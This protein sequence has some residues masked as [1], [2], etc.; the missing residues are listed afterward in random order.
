[1]TASPIR[2][3]ILGAADIAPDA[4]INP[5]KSVEE[6]EITSVA[7][8]DPR[9]AAEFA[10]EHGIP[11]VLETYDALLADPDI[12]LIYNPTPNGL[13]GR[14]TVAA[15]QAG[16]HVLCEKPF[17]ANAAEAREVAAAIARADRIVI[18]AFHYRYHPLIARALEIS[19]SGELGKVVSIEAGFGGMG[20]PLDDI[21]WSLPLAGGALMDVGCYP[22]HLVRTLAGAQPEVVAARA[23]MSE[24]GV[25]ADMD[26]DLRFPEGATGRVRTSMQSPTQFLYATVTGED[27]VLEIENPFIPMKGNSLTVRSGSDVRTEKFTTE[28][29]YLFQLRAV[30]DVLLRG[31]PVLTD[32][33]DAIANMDVI[34]AAYRAA[35]LEP[36]SPTV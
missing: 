25:D 12:D 13:H 21:R 8:R 20:R 35:G 28:P 32:T 3:G 2:V 31:A 23:D 10:A 16:K 18:E 26:I 24:T 1:M 5:A 33:A 11:R 34:D 17:T 30:A 29:S 9:R 27:G 6:V 15:V 19:R 36:H 4:L 7:A 14:W 22:V